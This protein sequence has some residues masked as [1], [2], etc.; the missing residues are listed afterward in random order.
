VNAEFERVFYKNLYSFGVTVLNLYMVGYMISLLED[1]TDVDRL[2]AEPIGVILAIPVATPHTI[3][4]PLSAR[5]A[6][7]TARSTLSKSFRRISLK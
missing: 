3:T 7:S 2:M 4:R 1:F 5:T 6:A